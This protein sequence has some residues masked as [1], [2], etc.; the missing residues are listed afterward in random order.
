MLHNVHTFRAKADGLDELSSGP[1]P[2]VEL[3]AILAGHQRGVKAL[4]TCMLWKHE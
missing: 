3:V 2:K 1:V 4:N